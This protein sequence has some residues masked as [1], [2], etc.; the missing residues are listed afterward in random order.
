[1]GAR[2]RHS[3][4]VTRVP[5]LSGSLPRPLEYANILLVCDIVKLLLLVLVRVATLSKTRSQER[6]I[7]GNSNN[8]VDVGILK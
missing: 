1:M 4:F 7:C 6:Q 5:I 8:K 2:A 3:P